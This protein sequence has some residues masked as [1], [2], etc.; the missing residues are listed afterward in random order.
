MPRLQFP[1]LLPEPVT[2]YCGRVFENSELRGRHMR[3]CKTWK[4]MSREQKK[5]HKER[6]KLLSIL[7]AHNPAR[8]RFK[9]C[10]RE[11]LSLAKIEVDFSPV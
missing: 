3:G 9:F 1:W 5:E 4:A 6:T 2:C 10:M 11:L 7:R 8:G